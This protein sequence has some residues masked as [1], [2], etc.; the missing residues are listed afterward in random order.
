M[1]VAPTLRP[2]ELGPR[3]GA[4]PTGPPVAVRKIVPVR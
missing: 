2:G 3:R 4:P 1:T